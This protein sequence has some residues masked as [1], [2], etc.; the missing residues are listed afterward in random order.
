MH[1]YDHTFY[2]S[3]KSPFPVARASR[4]IAF[5]LKEDVFN[6]LIHT[7]IQSGNLNGIIDYHR[8]RNMYKVK[9]NNYVFLELKQDYGL[10]K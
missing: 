8:V 6:N 1:W 7:Y 10:Y 9:D 3:D 2:S 5:D 4:G